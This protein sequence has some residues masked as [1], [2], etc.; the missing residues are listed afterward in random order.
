MDQRPIGAITKKPAFFSENTAAWLSFAA[1]VLASVAIAF[2]DLPY[3]SLPIAVL[4]LAYVIFMARRPAAIILAAVVL[5]VPGLLLTGL[6]FGDVI[7]SGFSIGVVLFALYVAPA[8]GSLLIFLKKTP[9][10]SLL[11]SAIAFGLCALISG[12]QLLRALPALFALPACLLLSLAHL[13][14]ERRSIVVMAAQAGF[15]FVVLA[16]VVAYFL[17]N[18]GKLD[19]ETVLAVA[20]QFRGELL[21]ALKTVRNELFESFQNANLEISTSLQSLLGDD[22]LQSL[23][24][25]LTVMLPGLATAL[26]G[27]LA[28]LGHSLFLTVRQNEGDEFAKAPESILFA[29]GIPSAVVYLSALALTAFLDSATLPYAV[30]ENLSIILLLPFCFSGF[31]RALAFFVIAPRGMRWLFI[32]FF[33]VLSFFLPGGVVGVLAF[34]TAFD[35]IFAPIRKKILAKK[36]GSGDN[37]R[38]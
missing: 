6:P 8:A 23:I 29:M 19:R 13:R 24:Q 35:T 31:Q 33:L 4:L 11:A 17:S 21:E 22:A 20:D 26:C 5:T 30:A 10:F 27:V 3:V 1:L 25:T 12:G 9:V 28:F 14:K 38:L 16:V 36:N 15:L 37:D 7:F 34:Y 2:P 32:V 18:Y